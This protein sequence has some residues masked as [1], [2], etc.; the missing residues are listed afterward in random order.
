[1]LDLSPATRIFVALIG[2]CADLEQAVVAAA[3]AGHQSW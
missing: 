2:R 3:D 1:M